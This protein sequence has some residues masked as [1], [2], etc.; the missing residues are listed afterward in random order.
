METLSFS[1]KSTRA[2]FLGTIVSVTG[3]FV[4]TLYQGPKLIWSLSPSPPISPVSL[5]SSQANW[6][7]GGLFLT[8]EYILVPLWYIVQV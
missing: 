6:A 1:K 5:G 4:V 8:S 2:K 3:A 7:L